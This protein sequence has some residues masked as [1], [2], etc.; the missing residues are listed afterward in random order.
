MSNHTDVHVIG[1]GLGGLATA[2]LVARAGHT[3]TVHE[4]RGRL[5]GRATTDDRNG[6]RFN[7]GPHA[8]YVGGEGVRVL[9][10][11]GIRPSGSPPPV[12][13]TQ[14][15]VAGERHLAPVGPISLLRTGMLRGREKIA[16]AKLLARLAKLDPASLSTVTV[17]DWVDSLTDHARVRQILHTLVRLATYTN[18]P[19]HLSAEVAVLQLQLALDDGVIY[20]DRGWEQLVHGLSSI[21]GVTV[22]TGERLTALPE[23]PAVVIA[24][25]GPEV[26]ASL[27]G[28][29]FGPAV[30]AEV[31]VLDLGLSRPATFDA[32][33]GADRPFYLS[34]HGFPIDMVPEGRSS[35]SIAQYLAPGDEPARDELRA[36]A[37]RAGIAPGQVVDERYLHRMTAVTAIATA[38]TGGLAG[39]APVAVSDREGV[40]VV[41]DWVGARAHLVDAVLASAEEAAAGVVAHLARRPVSR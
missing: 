32:V 12:R 1:G 7:Q 35:A 6:F 27:S 11:L 3:V 29:D 9:A 2:A 38:D 10:E 13:G 33:L 31:A 36:F 37:A 41:G 21:E 23:A 24:A 16:V 28:H 40:F 30:A 17:D 5:G 4:S 8:L 19:A 25:G 22:E 20:L 18:A 26:A 39:R 14:M 15:V 34:N